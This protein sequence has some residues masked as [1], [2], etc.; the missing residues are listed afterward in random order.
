MGLRRMLR[1][2]AGCGRIGHN[3]TKAQGTVLSVE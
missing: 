1:E 2:E 3:T